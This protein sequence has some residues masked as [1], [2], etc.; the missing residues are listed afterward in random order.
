MVSHFRASANECIP[1]N[2]NSLKHHQNLTYG[3]ARDSAAPSAQPFVPEPRVVSSSSSLWSQFKAEPQ[4]HTLQHPYRHGDQ[5]EDPRSRVQPHYQRYHC[6][7][8]RRFVTV[9]PTRAPRAASLKSVKSLDSV[10]GGISKAFHHRQGRHTEIIE[11]R[12]PSTISTSRTQGK[13]LPCVDVVQSS[14]GFKDLQ[15]H[16]LHAPQIAHKVAP[17]PSATSASSKWDTFA[18]EQSKQYP[19][20]QHSAPSKWGAFV[21]RGNAGVSGCNDEDD[22]FVTCFD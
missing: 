5:P 11:T 4:S 9:P 16:S 7:F 14:S 18:K 21:D 6:D 12:V 8:F 10:Q 17:A 20:Q 3:L 15:V 1:H 22:G 2:S 19:H 13:L